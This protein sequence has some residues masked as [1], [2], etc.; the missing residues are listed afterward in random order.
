[1]KT[2]TISKRVMAPRNILKNVTSM[3]S[4]AL[5]TMAQE[6]FCNACRSVVGYR[7]INQY[8]KDLGY[9][10]TIVFQPEAHVDMELPVETVIQE[11]IEVV[12]E[13]EATSEVETEVVDLMAFVQETETQ[14]TSSAGEALFDLMQQEEETIEELDTD[15]FA[16]LDTYVQETT[17][18]T[19]ND[20][21]LYLQ[22]AIVEDKYTEAGQ[23]KGRY[24]FQL[25]SGV[26]NGIHYPLPRC[27]SKLSKTMHK[28]YSEW[29]EKLSEN[30][31]ARL[32]TLMS[33][34]NEE[35]TNLCETIVKNRSKFYFV[36]CRTA[37]SLD[38]FYA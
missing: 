35:F 2:I 28:F 36:D 7:Q 14:T 16:I 25:Y 32:R 5:M 13:L 15:L 23:D 6:R 30:D 11:V 29:K 37:S 9:D 26:H 18:Y 33:Q 34:V 22:S 12:A 24:D 38:A 8:L 20:A 21:K 4:L 31:L 1:M 17:T 19:Y 10:V 27:T 3:E